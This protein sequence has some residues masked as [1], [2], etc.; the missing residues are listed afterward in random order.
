MASSISESGGWPECQK[1]NMLIDIE[2]EDRGTQEIPREV[3]AGRTLKKIFRQTD[4]LPRVREQPASESLLMNPSRF[5]IFTHLFEHPCD[6]TRSIAR[7]VDGSLTG[8]NWNLGQLEK[9]GYVV[10]FTVDSRKVYWPAGMLEPIDVPSV[11]LLT[12]PWGMIIMSMIG[13]AGKSS[14]HEI[15]K[16]MNESQQTV[17]SRLRKFE[18]VGLIQSTGEGRARRY[19]LSQNASSLS[20]KYTARSRDF[21]KTVWSL[22]RNDG[23]MPA[24]RRFTGTKL[25]GDVLLPSGKRRIH[26]EC[27]PVAPISKLLGHDM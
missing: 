16:A 25:S 21:S 11:R 2:P 23:L 18:C 20:E 4:G 24:K 10:S 3:T 1:E 9:A 13:N 7:K 26:L 14:Q 5:S 17:E 15:T 19:T 8:I 27:N 12:L 6:H 22:L